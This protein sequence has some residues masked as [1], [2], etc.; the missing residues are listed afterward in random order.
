MKN[1]REKLKLAT[2][3]DNSKVTLP[4]FG[5]NFNDPLLDFNSSQDLCEHFPGL[6]DGMHFVENDE[7]GLNESKQSS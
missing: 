7:E 4:A 1:K 3:N 2:A 6:I 5:Q